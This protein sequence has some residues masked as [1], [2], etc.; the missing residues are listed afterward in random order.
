MLA[1]TGTLVSGCGSG[2]SNVSCSPRYEYSNAY[3]KISAQ[4][5]GRGYG[6][7]WGAYPKGNPAGTYTA[8]VYIN[9]R[10]FDRKVQTYPP[11]GSVPASAVK[12]GD[13]FRLDGSLV[14]GGSTQ[15]FW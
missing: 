2:G 8:N 11:H 6:I 3:G 10:R 7:A 4:Q 13:I 15:K 9:G 5:R 14:T 12:T 1:L